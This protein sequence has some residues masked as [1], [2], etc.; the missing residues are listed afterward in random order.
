MEKDK[1]IRNVLD[2]INKMEAAEPPP[3][4]FTRIEQK[5]QLNTKSSISRN[6]II[7]VAVSYLLLILLNLVSI[8]K[9][10]HFSGSPNQ[11]ERYSESIGLNTS[12]QI[13]SD[14]E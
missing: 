5:I 1:W 2:S 4:L 7:G 10:S 9:S 3:F 8:K 11:L 6:W 14:S 12:N 13:Y